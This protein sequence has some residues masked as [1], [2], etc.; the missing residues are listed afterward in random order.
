MNRLGRM[1]GTKAGAGPNGYCKCPKCG[2]TVLHK[3]G[4]PCYSR[5]CSK[6][7]VTMIRA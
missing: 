4:I 6:C 3:R 2:K 1:G 5:K 7:V